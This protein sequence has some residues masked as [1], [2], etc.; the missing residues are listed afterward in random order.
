VKELLHEHGFEL[1]TVR[2]VV[3]RGLAAL[4]EEGV[5]AAAGRGRLLVH[6]LETLRRHAA[7]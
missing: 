5:I 7:G 6:D 2:E 4:R 1:G 3:V